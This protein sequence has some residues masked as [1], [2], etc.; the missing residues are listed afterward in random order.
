[1]MEWDTNRNINK[2]ALIVPS[3]AESMKVINLI[4][5]EVSGSAKKAF[6]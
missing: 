5:W 3:T 6:R 4:T 2:E 1:M